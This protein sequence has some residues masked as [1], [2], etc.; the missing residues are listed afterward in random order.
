MNRQA[1]GLCSICGEPLRPDD[2]T[3]ECG[4]G[5]EHRECHDEDIAA[6]QE[7]D[8]EGEAAERDAERDTDW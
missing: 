8:E 6:G 3:V 4:Y 1:S 7:F 5:P 2:Q